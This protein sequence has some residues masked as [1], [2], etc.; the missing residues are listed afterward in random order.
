MQRSRC[1]GDVLDTDYLIIGAGA[2]GLA[3]ADEIIAHSDADIIL[4][5]R[6]PTV[7]G[8]W[9]DAYPFVTLHQP[10]AFYGVGSVPLG[11][12][13]IETRGPNAGLYEQA[14]GLE[15]LSHFDRAMKD[16]LLASGRVRFLA[17]HDYLGE[18]QGTHRIRSRVTGQT[19]AIR[20]RRRLVD[21]GFYR[22]STPETHTP[23][24]SIAPDTPFTTPRRLPG[25]LPGRSHVAILGGG[26]TSMDVAI[27]L[28]EAGLGPERISWVRPRDS[29][30][31]NRETAQPGDEGVIRIAESQANKLDAS[32]K[33]TSLEDLFDRL[34]AHGELLRIDPGTRPEMFHGATIS[35]GEVALLARVENVIREGH[36]RRVAPGRL[37]FAAT[38]RGF[39]EDTLFVD[40]TAR[41]F[42]YQPT[43]P[44]FEPGRITL[45]IV[46]EGLVCLSAAAIGYVE[47]R[48][49]DDAEKNRL[50]PPV[51]Y[52]EHAIVWARGFLAELGV[53]AAW[54]GEKA[55]RQWA[56]GHRLTGFG[57]PRG[58]AAEARMAELRTAIA[59]RRPL[60][61]ANLERL[62]ENHGAAPLYR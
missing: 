40:C 56:R 35:R 27:W 45:Q 9:N 39:P 58:E 34:E 5:D 24:F 29:W 19:F 16:S 26:K 23:G 32:M 41:A 62:I 53:Q 42:H 52:E 13:R 20:A 18:A 59:Q 36:V 11:S 25:D 28:L 60:A 10:S 54:A 17:M 51:P 15:V 49:E 4:V 48:F 55:L 21:T 50:C 30:L 38:R 33:A 14:S 22:V 1:K 47:A 12:G 44:V 7:G 57:Q 37:D 43:R 2:Q 61:I 46:R 3:F 6:R 31:I 8:H